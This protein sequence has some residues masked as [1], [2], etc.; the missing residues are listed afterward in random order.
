[1]KEYNWAATASAAEAPLF[2][3]GMF[4]TFIGA[5]F[6]CMEASSGRYCDKKSLYFGL[7]FFIF[8]ILFITG[9]VLCKGF[10]Q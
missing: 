3:L 9:G 10:V 4:M 8:G 7:T 6:T 2:I 1:M 5:V